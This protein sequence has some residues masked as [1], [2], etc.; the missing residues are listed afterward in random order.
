VSPSRKPEYII[1]GG[2]RIELLIGPTCPVTDP[3]DGRRCALPKGHK[4]SHKHEE[5]AS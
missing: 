2:K 5:D 3:D 4:G 1:V